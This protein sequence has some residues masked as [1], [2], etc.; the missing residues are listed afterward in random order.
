MQAGALGPGL[1]TTVYPAVPPDTCPL[2]YGS[3]PVPIFMFSTE[4]LTYSPFNVGNQLGKLNA[5]ICHFWPYSP[6]FFISHAI[7]DEFHELHEM[8]VKLHIRVLQ[9][10]SKLSTQSSSC[11]AREATISPTQGPEGCCSTL[12][13]LCVPLILSNNIIHLS[14]CIPEVAICPVTLTTL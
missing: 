4:I 8:Q 1:K 9:L 7:G 5:D 2:R 11:P 13:M 10:S 12:R 3:D 6:L 14:W